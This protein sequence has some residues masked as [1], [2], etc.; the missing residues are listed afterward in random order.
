MRLGVMWLA[1]DDGPH[2]GVMS[3]DQTCWWWTS[4]T[5]FCQQ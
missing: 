3:T 2:C 4:A 5:T 1:A